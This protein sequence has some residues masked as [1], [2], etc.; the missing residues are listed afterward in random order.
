MIILILFA[1]LGGIIT[2]LSPCILPILPI[3]LSGSITGGKRRPMGVVTGFILSFTFF[4]LFLSAIVRATGLSP[5][6]LR[7]TAVVIISFFGISLL[8]PMLQKA[9][10]KIFSRLT[11]LAPKQNTQDGYLSGILVGMSLGLLWT[12][13]VGPILASIITLAAT[14]SVGLNAI[15][16]TLSYAIGTAIPLLAI[17]IG[18]RNLL[19][20]HPWL[21]KNTTTI[22]KAFGV[23]MLLTAL[24]ILNSWDRKFQ[25]YILETFPSYGTGLTILEDNAIVRNQLD[26]LKG[27]SPMLT[28]L[29]SE[30]YGNAPEFIPGGQWFNSQPLSMRELRGKVVLVDFW[31]YTCINCIRTLPYLTSWHEKYKDKGL[32]IVGVHT[33]E[34]EFEKNPD[35]VKKAIQDFGIQYPVM[36]DNN[37][38][39]WQAYTNRYW[40]AKY[41]TDKNGKIRYTHFGEGDYDETEKMI[42]KLLEETGVTVD[43]QVANPT[44]Q[45]Q[46]RTPETYLGYERM[47]GLVSPERVVPNKATTFTTP[48]NIQSNRFALHGTWTIGAERA[49]P[50]TGATL[51]YH[52]EAAEVFLV[53]RPNTPGAAGGIRVYLDDVPVPDVYKGED[54]QGG[55]VKINEDRLYKLIKLPAPG[56]HI[57][58]LEVLDGDIELY[59]FTFG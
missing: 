25:T 2:I 6:T 5:D 9:T 4:T 30:N 48:V 57:L 54:V 40:P 43:E 17:T 36:Q 56:R 46:S 47:A 1:F 19:T 14:S 55:N 42:Q 26:T 23:L 27:G 39:T 21:L 22:Q 16:I 49:M 20:N 7:M 29:L 33:P 50:T 8:V 35:N 44:Y 58:K 45:V 32:V 51:T 34:F 37:Y 24:A 10:E 18:G 38:A 13:C 15:I 53:I 41:M 31:T 11:Q 28:D 3:V 59:A 12:P 52:F